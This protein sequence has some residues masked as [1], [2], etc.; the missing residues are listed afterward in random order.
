MKALGK[1][2]SK[3]YAKLGVKLAMLPVLALVLVVGFFLGRLGGSSEPTSPEGTAQAETQAKAQ[4][5]TCSMH[6]QIR[7]PKKGLCPICNMDLIPAST[8]EDSGAMRQLT[9]SE[10]ARKLMDIV[11]APVERK[12]VSAVVRMV[13]KVDYDET[14]LAYITAWFPG[15][16]DRLYIDYTGVPVKEGDH[17]FD[18]YSPELISA[19][20]ELLQALEAVKNVQDTQLSVMREMTESTV[21]AAREKLRLWGLKAEQIEKIE[22]TGKVQDHV[23]IYAPSGGI[24]IHKN[25]LERMYVQTGTRIY[26]I[27]DLSQVWVKMDA[28]ESDLEW[29]RYGQ[30]VEFTTVSYPGSVFKGTISFIDPILNDRTRSVKIRINV[31]NADG[32][33]KPGMFVKAAVRAN[34]AAGGRIMEAALAGKW[35]CPMHPEVVKSNPGK[36]DVCQMPLV[37]TESLGY[38]SDDPEVAQKPLVIPVSAALVTGT[39][40]IV[41]V[42]VPDTDKPTFEGREIV[43]GPRAGDY[44]LVRS[45]LN[46]GE[47]VV[48]KGNFKIDSSLQIMA[49][50]SMMTPEGAGGGGMHD[51]GPKTS[52]GSTAGQAA[53]ELPPLFEYQL[54]AVLAAA[55]NVGAAAAG[56]DISAIQSTFSAVGQAIQDIDMEQ[57]SGHVHML[58][59]EVSMRLT[60][61]A[62]EGAQAKTLE[63]ARRIA[64]G[65]SETLKS[66]RSKFGLVH[67]HAMETRPT[68]NSELRDQ[69]ARVFGRYFAMHKALAGDTSALAAK[70]ANETLDALRGVDMGLLSGEDHDKW[71]Q[72]S[73]DLQ[74]ILTKAGQTE[75]IK[76]QREE[77]YLLSQQMTEV[78]RRFG[79]ALQGPV[80]LLH[81]PMAF[82]NKGAGWLQLDDQDDQTLNPYFGA[83]M[84]QCGGVEEVIGAKAIWKEKD[85]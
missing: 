38:A 73:T 37:T 50:P 7:L 31:S 17:M 15:R 32:R 71:M 72:A 22:R 56:Q 85:N 41:Y 1:K 75:D 55:E 27:A 25:A 60:N 43:L 10:N 59:M 62:V 51:H 3:I 69:L 58:W 34:V 45:G 80:Y 46:E 54:K 82:D 2:T 28:Y 65:L 76:S 57:L 67:E 48:V 33:L 49:K 83:Q 42:Q 68:I 39:R 21:I 30:E 78:A 24:V 14:R 79:S 8:G 47:L 29:L 61:D 84:L 53:V 66:T 20:E 64:V 12:F 35:I 74:A 26:T 19:Q 81:C 6:P 77:F 9:V 18:L 11:T 4:A 36:C 13:G 44:Y 40:A 70:A 16:L 5:W 23:T 63:D 52:Q